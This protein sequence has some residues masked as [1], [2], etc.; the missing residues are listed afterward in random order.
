MT[1][2]RIVDAWMPKSVLMRTGKP[3]NYVASVIIYLDV[4]SEFRNE[5][6]LS[7]SFFETVFHR[8]AP[9]EKC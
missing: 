2:E 7:R 3:L 6:F 9:T 5:G 8:N 1:E 4:S